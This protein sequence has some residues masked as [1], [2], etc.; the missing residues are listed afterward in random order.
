MSGA[1]SSERDGRTRVLYVGGMPRS[2]STLLTWIIG[3]LPGHVAIGELF[4]LWSAG[5]ARNQLCGCGRPFSDCPFWQQVGDVAFGGWETVTPRAEALIGEVDTTSR[6]PSILSA[7]LRPRFGRRMAE[8]LDLLEH[9][10]GAAATVADGATVVDGSK[11]PSTA[12]L[13][14]AS[15]KIDL[16]VVQIVRDPR[17]VVQSWSK[18][19]ELPSGAGSR[20]YLKVRST[21]Q[22]TRRWITVN[23]T[24][25]ALGLLGVPLM[26]VRYEDLVREPGRVVQEIADFAGVHAD[27]D[28]TAFVDGTLVHLTPAHMVEGG[29]VRFSQSPLE[30]RLD[31]RWRSEMPVARRRLVDVVTRPARRRYGYR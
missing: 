2:G 24:I 7:R 14:R 6:I 5:I 8:Y 22:I 13:L 3:Q 21:R 23:A 28:P 12:Y 16:R 26:T 10:Y 27:T 11:R 30:M 19:V 9:V 31:E 25:R 18:Q 4:Y 29:R 17:G 20:G 15:R 1:D